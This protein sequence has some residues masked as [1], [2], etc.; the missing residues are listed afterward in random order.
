MRA[1][2]PPIPGPP[3]LPRVRT[4]PNVLPARPL[5]HHISQDNGALML[6]TPF[7]LKIKRW[8]LA[9]ILL[10]VELWLGWLGGTVV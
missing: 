1:L 9:A 2:T 7:G 6:R 10:A 4:R 8:L 5:R 3:A